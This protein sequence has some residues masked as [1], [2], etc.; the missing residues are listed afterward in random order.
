MQLK[1]QLG[2]DKPS[3]M[4]GSVRQAGRMAWYRGGLAVGALG[5]AWWWISTAKRGEELQGEY[6][7]ST[8]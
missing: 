7:G 3:Q 1:D 6:V 8:N 4:S 2:P 5:V